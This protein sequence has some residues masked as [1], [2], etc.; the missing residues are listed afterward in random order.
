MN[1]AAAMVPGGISK[2]VLDELKHY[3]TSGPQPYRD[4]HECCHST[5]N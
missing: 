2:V 5:D 1:P 4:V 3:L